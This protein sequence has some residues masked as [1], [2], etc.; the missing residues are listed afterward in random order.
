MTFVRIQIIR[1]F[2][3][4]YSVLRTTSLTT[5]SEI[6]SLLDVFFIKNS[7]TQDN[8]IDVC[9]NGA[10]AVVGNFVNVVTRIKKVSKNCTSRLVIVY[11]PDISPKKKKKTKKMSV[12][13]KQV[14]DNVVKII[15]IVKTWLLQCRLFKILCED[16]RLWGVV[17]KLLLL[18]ITHRSTMVV[19]M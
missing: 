14:V 1:F 15:S 9:I 2:S 7:I 6:F 4:R 11:Y 18:L 3:W 19:T 17:N 5:G 8:C 12:L 16:M 13:L 10:K